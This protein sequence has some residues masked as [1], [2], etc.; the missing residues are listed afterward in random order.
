MKTNNLILMLLVVA[1]SFLLGSTYANQAPAREDGRTEEYAIM[2]VMQIN[3]ER[4]IRI[5]ITT[6]A[7][8]EV[9]ELKKVESKETNALMFAEL[10]NLNAKGFELFD[11]NF[12][13]P[14]LSFYYTYIF[15]R[16]L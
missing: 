11:T 3:A 15:K 4:D 5:S 8:T 13:T 6:S 12:T 2:H 14:G 9:Q 10:N 16:K 7:G 1:V